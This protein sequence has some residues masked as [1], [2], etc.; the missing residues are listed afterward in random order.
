MAAMSISP[1]NRHVVHEPGDWSIA[2]N[3]RKCGGL[4][5]SSVSQAPHGF[6]GT[7]LDFFS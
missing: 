7:E 6:H 2:V 3:P 4:W 1:W 5:A